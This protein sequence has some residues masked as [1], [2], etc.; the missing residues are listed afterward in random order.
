MDDD[1]RI[2]HADLK[3]GNDE[4]SMMLRDLDGSLTG[5]PNMSVTANIPYY[6]DGMQ[7]NT[8]SHWNMSVCNGKSARV[9][10]HNKIDVCIVP[11]VLFKN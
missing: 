10:T 6:H 2:C 3:T 4:F 7:C 8:N 11:S 1:D 5:S 9:R